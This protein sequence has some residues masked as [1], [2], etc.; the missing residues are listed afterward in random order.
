ME[1]IM[2]LGEVL[3]DNQNDLKKYSELVGDQEAQINLLEN[4]LAELN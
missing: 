2:R 4:K 1:E 3:Q